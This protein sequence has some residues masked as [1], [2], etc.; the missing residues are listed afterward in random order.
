[1]ALDDMMDTLRKFLKVRKM[2]VDKTKLLIFN[3]SGRLGK[4]EV[5]W[6]NKTIEEVKAFRF[7]L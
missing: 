7:Q 1:M 6:G 4:E 2:E 3:S 5:K